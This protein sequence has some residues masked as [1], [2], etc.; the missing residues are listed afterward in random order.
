[1]K[2]FVCIF[3][4]IFSFAMVICFVTFLKKSNM[5]K[6]VYL[7]ELYKLNDHETLYKIGEV[8]SSGYKER[9]RVPPFLYDSWLE[10]KYKET[11]NEVY[12]DIYYLLV[13]RN[14]KFIKF[15]L[16]IWIPIMV[17]FAIS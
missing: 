2:F 13:D 16:A 10:T 4:L 14:D 6:Q 7:D 12:N 8:N 5:V 15:G 1:M 9:R 3:L 11:N 17:I